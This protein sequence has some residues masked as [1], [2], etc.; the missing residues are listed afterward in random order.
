L[1]PSVQ[2]QLG[3]ELLA[4]HQRPPHHAWL[5]L[6]R[7]INDF[8]RAFN[9]PA[10]ESHRYA[11]ASTATLQNGKGA[12]RGVIRRAA[13]AVLDRRA[14]LPLD[15]MEDF[16]AWSSHSLRSASWNF[17]C[18]PSSSRTLLRHHLTV[19]ACRARAT[20]PRGGAGTAHGRSGHGSSPGALRLR[21]WA[22]AD[23]VAGRR[24][25][26]SGAEGPRTLATGRSTRPGCYG[27]PRSDRVD[28]ARA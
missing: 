16:P 11:V 18:L 13:A 22:P 21:A 9:S 15:D 27:A 3:A 2:A 6:P 10:A 25:I 24:A 12:V 23:R 14:I 19:P 8:G 4:R 7:S 26:E 20:A 5:T 28:A 17:A 1:R